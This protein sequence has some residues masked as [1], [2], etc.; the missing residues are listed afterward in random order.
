MFKR[1]LSAMVLAISVLSV[2]PWL[3]SCGGG[4]TAPFQAE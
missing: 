4:N 3:T 1:Y 2:A